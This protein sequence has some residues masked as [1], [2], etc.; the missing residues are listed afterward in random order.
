MRYSIHDETLDAKKARILINALV[1]CA[2][3]GVRPSFSINKM[4]WGVSLFLECGSFNRENWRTYHRVSD[5]AKQ[6]RDSGDKSWKKNV[7]FEH[8]RP[9]SKMYQM[10][11]DERETLTQDRAALIIGEY[12]PVLITVKEELRMSELGFKHGGNP[13]ERYAHIPIG[14]FT[15]RSE[16]APR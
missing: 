10:L 6:V 2:K 14:G 13:E 1:D 15:L 9:I 3:A 4:L 12:P 7:T 16:A 5:A 8:V 11:L